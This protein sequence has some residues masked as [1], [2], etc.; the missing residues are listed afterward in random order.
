MN[1]KELIAKFLKGDA[2]TD[3]EKKSLAEFDPDTIAAA[4]RKGEADKRKQAEK[5]KADL[6]AKFDEAQ[7]KLDEAAESGKSAAEKEK[8]AVEKTLSKL[9]AAEEKAAKIEADFSAHRRNAKL[10][11]LLGSLKFVDGL[12][13]DL[14]RP[15]FREKFKDLDETG[16]NDENAT[17]AILTEFQKASKG[18]LA[19]TSGHGGGSREKGSGGFSRDADPSKQSDADRLKSLRN[20]QTS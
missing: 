15:A 18:I 7:A 6:Q 4:A 20:L 19:D 1:L 11:S 16:L 10:D 3:D 13:P 14:I 8:A 2:L 9:K 17:K 12:D 5:E